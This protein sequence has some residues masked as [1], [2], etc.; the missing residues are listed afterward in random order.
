MLAGLLRHGAPG[1]G[2]L[3]HD[4]LHADVKRLGAA[5]DWHA[6][7]QR[8]TD[9]FAGAGSW[10]KVPE[11]RRDSIAAT[12]KPNYLEFDAGMEVIAPQ[13]LADV[14]AR[15]LVLRGSQA[16]RLNQEISDAVVA[17]VPDARLQVLDGAGHMGPATH[18]PQ[19]NEIV[20]AFLRSG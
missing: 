15:T 14:T 20:A 10:Q 13:T 19:F 17:A 5:G 1:A 6:L 12:L 7:A 3:E 4:A 11:A 2:L 9:Y 18:A 16:T 8:F